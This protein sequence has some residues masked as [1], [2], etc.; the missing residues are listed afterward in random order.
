MWIT[1]TL[2]VS[3]QQQHNNTLIKI[4]SDHCYRQN[5]R[6]YRDIFF[7]SV[8]HT[9]TIKISHCFCFI[10]TLKKKYILWSWPVY[11][12]SLK[13]HSKHADVLVLQNGWQWTDTDLEVSLSKSLIEV[14]MN[15]LI[16]NSAVCIL[17]LEMAFV[18][19]WK[20]GRTF[21]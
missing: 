21:F 9:P 6:K 1:K 7:L 16:H 12:A 3:C 18:T 13:P 17:C 10:V 5:P 15:L 11:S 14:K 2:G 20:Q 19:K 8:L 4:S